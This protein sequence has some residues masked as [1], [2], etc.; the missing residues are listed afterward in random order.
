M[1]AD[2]L[3]A[4]PNPLSLLWKTQLQ[5]LTMLAIGKKGNKILLMTKGIAIIRGSELFE[6]EV[7][8]QVEHLV[9][10]I[11][12]PPSPTCRW[13]SLHPLLPTSSTSRTAR[14][15]PQ[16]LIYV[17][18]L[19]HPRTIQPYHLEQLSYATISCWLTLSAWF[20]RR[21]SGAFPQTW[22]HYDNLLRSGSVCLSIQEERERAVTRE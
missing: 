14:N 11:N 3:R 1:E 17:N 13:L 7:E 22:N 6:I 10:I 15:C 8:V 16:I 12:S 4:E 20:R 5:S 21:K 9:Y 18:L 19:I 2:K